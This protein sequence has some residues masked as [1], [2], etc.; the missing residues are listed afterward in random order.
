L[1]GGLAHPAGF[2]AKRDEFPGISYECCKELA[3][4]DGGDG[5]GLLMI[6]GLGKIWGVKNGVVSKISLS[7][8]SNVL[9]VIVER[10]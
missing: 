10:N 2:Y 3:K 1:F 6:F 7:N 4:T 8:F 5:S 9:T